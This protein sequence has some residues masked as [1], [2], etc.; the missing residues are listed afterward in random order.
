M[1]STV[2]APPHLC[3]KVSPGDKT[4]FSKCGWIIILAVVLFKY[5]NDY[6]KLNFLL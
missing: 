5:Y 6:T 4:S 2:G 3:E 1:T